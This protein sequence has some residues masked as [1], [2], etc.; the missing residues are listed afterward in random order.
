MSFGNI[1]VARASKS[2]SSQLG[3]NTED[4]KASPKALTP[5]CKGNENEQVSCT[6]P[7]CVGKF[8]FPF[9][10]CL[11]LEGTNSV[12]PIC[13]Q[14]KGKPCAGSAEEA[15]FDGVR[16]ENPGT[17]PYAVSSPRAWI[18]LLQALQWLVPCYS[19]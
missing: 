4:Q 3:A 5:C 15:E 17:R 10:I 12:L 2:G 9:Q 13:F 14:A 16:G 19:T 7:Q 18:I 11:D 8:L 6:R 1:C